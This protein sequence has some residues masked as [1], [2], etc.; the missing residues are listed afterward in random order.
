MSML[1]LGGE[2]I[3]KRAAVVMCRTLT[4]EIDLE[5][6]TWSSVDHKM[7]CK[8]YFYFLLDLKTLVLD[9]LKTNLKHSLP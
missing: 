4:N 2:T 8:Y 7:S 1:S 5:T 3:V 6:N 9:N